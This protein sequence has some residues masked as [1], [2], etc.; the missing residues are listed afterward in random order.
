MARAHGGLADRSSPVRLCRHV[1]RL[2]GR[3][4]RRGLVRQRDEERASAAS[5]RDHSGS[6]D[7]T[8]IL[9]DVSQR[10]SSVTIYGPLP[11]P[12]RRGDRRSH[13]AV[14]AVCV[15]LGALGFCPAAQA[16]RPHVFSGSFGSAG[17]GAGELTEPSGLAVDES[18]GDV[19]VVD[20]GDDRVEIFNE[21]GDFEG[22]FDG[23]ATYEFEGKAESASA[24]P[25]GQLSAPEGIAVNNTC[26]LHELK[27][28]KVLTSTECEELDPSNGD[29]YVVNVGHDVVNKFTARGAYIGQIVEAS[30]GAPLAELDG[31][32]VDPDGRV[33]VYQGSGEIDR[34]SDAAVNEFESARSSEASGFAEPG[35]AVDARDDLYVVHTFGRI[36]AKL[37]ED[38]AVLIN[39]VGD[40][41]VS[42]LAS[43]P[44]TGDVYLDD[45]SSVARLDSGGKELERLGTG[46]LV[47]GTGVAVDAGTETVYVADAAKDAVNIFSRVEPGMPTIEHEAAATVSADEAELEAEVD[48]QGAGTTY[49]FEYGPCASASACASAPYAFALSGAE[50]P[51][52]FDAH[53]VAA[54]VEHLEPHSLYHYRVVAENTLGETKGREQL[55][56][57]EA[58]GGTLTL[59]DDRIWEQ[60]SPQDKRGGV[61]YPPEESSGSAHESGIVQAAADGGAIIYSSNLPTVDAPQGFQSTEQIVSSRF[62]GAWE[63]EDIATAHGQPSGKF[64]GRGQEYRLFSEDLSEAIVEPLGPFFALSPRAAERT[65]YLRRQE[66]CSSS[67]ASSECFVP[68]V[69]DVE[70]YADVPSGT[71]IGEPHATEG[72]FRFEYATPDLHHA[73]VDAPIP[74]AAGGTYEWFSGKPPSEELQLVTQL[75][76]SE[77]GEVVASSLGNGNGNGVPNGEPDVR[78]ALSDDGGRVFFSANGHLYAR[79]TLAAKPET[80]RLDVAQGVAEPATEHADFKIA[81]AEGERVFFTAGRLTAESAEAGDLYVCDITE[82]AGKLSCDLTDLTPEKEG[83]PAAVENVVGISEDGSYV[84]FV[85]SGVLAPG[86]RPG[87]CENE[88]E[89]RGATCNLYEI[90]WNGAHWE[91][92]TTVAVLAHDDLPDWRNDLERGTARVSPDGRYITFMSELSLTGYDNLDARSGQPDEEVYLYHAGEGSLTCVSCDPTGARPTGRE[93]GSNDFLVGGDRTWMTSQWLAADLPGWNGVSQ[94]LAIYQPRYLSNNGRVY[95]DSDTALVP[96]DVNGTWDVYEYEHPGV[97]GCSSASPTYFETS[98]GCIDLI[99]SGESSEESVFLDASEGG[100]TAFFLTEESLVAGDTDTA[101][102]VYAARE[103]LAGES[104][105]ATATTGTSSECTTVDTCR[106]SPSSEPDIFGTPASQTFAGPGDLG[107]APTPRVKPLSLA[108]KLKRALRAC[109]KKR[110]KHARLSC[111][112][113]ARRTYRAKKPARHAKKPPGRAP[114]RGKK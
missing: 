8:E 111:E 110:A 72:N 108:E 3:R 70:P 10:R 41:A 105:T 57:T 103:C 25:T 100:G 112:R 79:N 38:G 81:S 63:S 39:E 54:T 29:V 56:T 22:Q 4:A 6:N 49:R 9:Y 87:S 59:L 68:L 91:S 30:L 106:T 16:Q 64:L 58:L 2:A 84:Y 52:D 69:T 21:A 89:E 17:A 24:A 109:R 7:S 78:H 80:L 60:V 46:E 67:V 92:P 98:G 18:S 65:P 36:V 95:F 19:Y 104:C 50:L 20:K 43:E 35:L 53:R 96:Q 5:P 99:S 33:W 71:D 101:F 12:S 23:T 114:S 34:F 62:N 66:A 85:A 48:P 15:V 86:A 42:G 1:H 55:I 40:E 14:F 82:N 26:A 94:G 76:E 74:G 44:P 45:E 27:V 102:D 13:S 61:I 51:P 77:G 107:P 28:G 73:I 97:G 32:A 83:E 88:I 37:S 93:Y 75:P 90:H 47:Q 113:T 31:V 11:S